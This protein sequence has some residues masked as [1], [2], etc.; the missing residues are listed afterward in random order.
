MG[1][2]GNP[3]GSGGTAVGSSWLESYIDAWNR[4][5]FEGVSGFM[6]DDVVY[7]DVALG[8]RVEGR[9]AVR[10]FARRAADEFSSDFRFELTSSVATESAYAMEWTMTGTNDR[11]GAQMPA[12]NKP[13]SIRG[14]SFGRLSG[15]R[16][17]E[18]R[19][20]WNMADYLMQ[21]G[22]MAPPAAAHTG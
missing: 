1:R 21:V 22:L 9:A 3:I 16:I 20:Y 12:T 7:E 4:H 11:S 17:K 5:D 6:T 13:Y 14:I 15:G 10:E 8:E 19:D 2:S 18:N